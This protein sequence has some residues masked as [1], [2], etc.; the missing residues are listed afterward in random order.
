VAIE[1]VGIKG[2]HSLYGKKEYTVIFRVHNTTSGDIVG[3]L[4]HSD[5]PAQGSA[6]T[7]GNLGISI[8]DD[9]GSLALEASA[10]LPL[11]DL[12]TSWDVSIKYANE[13]PN[14]AQADKDDL[15]DSEPKLEWSTE[16]LEVFLTEDV[17]GDAIFNTAG[18]E[19]SDS[20]PR[21]L[22]IPVLTITKP[23]ATYS[24]ANAFV[25]NNALNSDVYRGGVAGTW[26][27]KITATSAYRNG[28]EYFNGKWVFKYNPYGWQP[29]ALN[30]GY[31]QLVDDGTGNMEHVPCTIKTIDGHDSEPV[32]IPAPLDINGTQIDKDLLPGAAIFQSIEAYPTLPYNA[33]GV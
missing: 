5:L 15:A 33:L 10:A 12:R 1:V 13:I 21:T 25:Y 29:T 7:S 23:V 31:Y 19:Y 24:A 4:T 22:Y 32:T 11:N 18:D 26:R 6:L 17:N 3:A 9:P 16:E 2:K 30:A 20:I 8:T 14:P 28:E 27:V